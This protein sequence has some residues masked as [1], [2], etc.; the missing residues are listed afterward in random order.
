MDST[1]SSG[2]YALAS[3]MNLHSVSGFAG[4]IGYTISGFIAS[5]DAALW[6]NRAMMG[7]FLA[8]FAAM[9][10][11]LLVKRESTD[12]FARNRVFGTVAPLMS[13]VFLLTF[14]CSGGGTTREYPIGGT[15]N[16][17]Y[18][19]NS[20]QALSGPTA[21]G[22]PLG[23]YFY[24]EDHLG[25][26]TLVTDATGAQTTRIV[27]YP[28]GEVDQANSMGTDSLTYKFTGQEYDPESS[29]HYYKAR[30]YDSTTGVF[31]TADDQV[32]NARAT[33]DHNRYMYVQGNPVKYTD[34]SGHYPYPLIILAGALGGP[35]VGLGV[36]LITSG[37]KTI[38]LCQF[39]GPFHR[40]ELN[41]EGASVM[42]DIA[43]AHD[44]MDGQGASARLIQGWHDDTPEQRAWNRKR[45]LD[46]IGQGALALLTLKF[47]WGNAAKAWDRTASGMMESANV[48]SNGPDWT[49]PL[50]AIAMLVVGVA[51]L[52]WFVIDWVST[53]A[54]DVTIW[55]AGSLMFAVDV[56]VRDTAGAGALQTSMIDF[57]IGLTAV[58]AGWALLS[59]IAIGSAG[60]VAMV[61]ILGAFVIAV[62]GI[63]LVAVVIHE[64]DKLFRKWFP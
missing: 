59:G 60:A 8:L 57:L 44:G 35:L 1:R 49:K 63:V 31:T 7:L 6:M 19:V 40:G 24:S 14:G 33:Q 9:V 20:T 61:T 25:S 64:I 13:L 16:G 5:A 15:V 50:G 2:A 53:V 26:G 17:M 46:F 32:H 55:A 18:H 30:Y 21:M 3:M 12:F 34:P 38:G 48:L 11:F 23:T 36:G 4:W 54:M 45:N 42:D 27:Y 39:A 43:K 62:A 28:Y 22:L 52:C 47:V 56:M 29:L 41:T 51:L 58:G 37:G 10:I